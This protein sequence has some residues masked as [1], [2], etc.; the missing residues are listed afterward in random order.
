MV[1]V[2]HRQ[3]ISV[4]AKL[5]VDLPATQTRTRTPIMN[6]LLLHIAKDEASVT[7][8]FNPIATAQ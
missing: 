3:H 7:A 6:S 1:P 2:P 4:E 5:I 8:T